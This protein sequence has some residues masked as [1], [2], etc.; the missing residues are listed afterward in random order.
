MTLEWP[1]R[2]DPKLDQV[3]RTYLFTEGP[4][5]AIEAAAEA[6]AG[7]EDQPDDGAGASPGPGSPPR[8]E[9]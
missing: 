4:I 2:R 8:E 1:R 6:A 7:D 9:P 5:T 3:L